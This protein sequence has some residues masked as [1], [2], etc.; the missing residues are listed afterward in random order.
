M[1]NY[2]TNQNILVND[3]TVSEGQMQK[4]NLQAKNTGSAVL[5]PL[6]PL[7]HYGIANNIPLMFKQWL[8]YAKGSLSIAALGGGEVL[9]HQPVPAAPEEETTLAHERGCISGYGGSSPH[10]TAAAWP[11][12]NPFL[13]LHL[14]TWS[15]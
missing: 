11:E 15:A 8:D 7:L 5:V 10:P 3:S 9:P 14:P 1:Q 13:H 6:S 2:K 4:D 12:E